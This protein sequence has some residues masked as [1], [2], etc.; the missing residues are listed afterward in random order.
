MISTLCTWAPALVLDNA[1]STDKPAMTRRIPTPPRGMH[2]ESLRSAACPSAPSFV[3]PGRNTSCAGPGLQ[4]LLEGERQ[5]HTGCGASARASVVDAFAPCPTG[6]Q[7]L[8][9]SAGDCHAV[10]EREQ[11]PCSAAP[12]GLKFTPTWVVVHHR[13]HAPNAF[14]AAFDLAFFSW[15]S[16][17][18]F[19]YPKRRGRRARTARRGYSRL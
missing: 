15:P 8:E 9:H 18:S 2:N 6:D 12:R 19:L 1:S 13:R 14:Q 16:P 17:P 5:E 7:A 3:P 10:R 4:P 11:K